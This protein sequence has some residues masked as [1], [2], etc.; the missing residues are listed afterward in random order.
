[1]TWDGSAPC[2]DLNVATTT[3]VPVS[4]CS[5]CARSAGESTFA[6]SATGVAG[7]G[8]TWNE[9][10]RRKNALKWRLEL[11]FGGLFRAG[12]GCL[13]RH[14]GREV[15]HAGNDRARE[16][17]H[18]LVVLRDRLVVLVPRIVDPILGTFELRHQACEGAIGFQVGIRLTR[19]DQ[20]AER[21]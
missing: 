12:R 11:Y 21:L 19:R 2:S 1:V 10:R 18:A 15:T 20:A 5:S 6:K 7:F 9:S 3:R 16:G 14:F 13:E 4:F 8:G 17:P